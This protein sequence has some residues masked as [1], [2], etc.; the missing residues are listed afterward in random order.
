MKTTNRFILVLALALAS[1]A[2]GCATDPSGMGDDDGGGGGG[3]GGDDDGPPRPLD[4]TGRYSVRS[5]FDLAT[6][7]PGTAGTVVNT[8][9]AATDEP[10]DPTQWIVDQILAQLSEGPVKSAL[11]AAKPFVVGY[12]NERLLQ[13][14]PDFLTTMVHVGHDFGDIARQFSLNETLEL[15]RSGTDYVA[16]HTLTGAHFKLGTV[17]RDY[18]LVT[19]RLP[20]VVVSN[21]AVT[22]NSSG[23]LTIAAHKLP[24]PYG[25]LLRVG[26][27][28]AII[29]LLDSTAH[30]LSE[31]LTHKVNCQTVGDAIGE[32]LGFGA[33]TFRTACSA[34]ITAGA[35][36]VYTKL[37]AINGSALEF[38]LS[39]SAQAAD[40]NNDR[41]IDAIQTGTWAGTLSYAG[42]PTPLIPAAFSAERR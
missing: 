10:A 4:A 8:I 1:G 33:S 37:D 6:N 31:L 15:T 22:M 9:I 42:S 2:A 27:D 17:E 12:L 23:Q 39:G 36:F 41:Q 14:A 26:L 20:N 28:A 3:G 25:Q 5:T 30:N 18:A 32:A 38:G 21:V 19:Y 24:M 11:N 13:F 16:V 7:M 34:G 40:N 29:P 35:N